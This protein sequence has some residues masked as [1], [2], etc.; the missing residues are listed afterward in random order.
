MGTY[1]K[2]PLYQK[3]GIKEDYRIYVKNAPIPYPTLF[4][5]IPFDLD[6]KKRI[7]AD[8]DFIHLFV[9][10]RSELET[11][12]LPLYRSLSQ[13]GLL[14]ISWPKGG[15]KITTDLNREFIREYVLDNGLVDVK[16][17]SINEDWSAL[18]F[19]YRLEDRKL[20]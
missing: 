1:S 13:S 5:K 18:K 8:L 11:S 6:L 17:C 20:K 15:S 3:L 14:W 2:T 7:S 16:V 4:G 19:V 10:S 12:Y 9:K